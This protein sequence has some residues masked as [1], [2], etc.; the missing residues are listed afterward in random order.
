MLLWLFVRSSRPAAGTDSY[1]DNGTTGELETVKDSGVGAFTATR[2]IEG[3]ITTERYP[4]GLDANYTYNQVGEPTGLEYK[5]VTDCSNSCT[6]YNDTVIPSVHGQWRTQTTS[7]SGGAASTLNYNYDGLGRLTEVQETPAGQGCTTRLYVYDEDGNRTSQT[8]R[9]PGSEGKCATTG[10]T[11]TTHTYDTAD[12]LDETGVSYDPFGNTT[13]LPAADAGGTALTSTYYVNDTLASQEQ[14]GETISYKLDPAGR[15]RETTA[16]GTTI[17]HYSGAGE[18]PAWTINKETEAW[19]RNVAN[20]AGAL[21][22]IQTSS[23][24]NT[25]QLANLHG[26]IIGTASTSESESKLA[27]ANETTEYGV[28]HTT[29][30]SKHSWLGTTGVSTELPTGVID[31]GARTYIPALGRFEQTDPQPGGSTNAYAYTFDDPVNQADPSGEWTYDYEAAQAGEA[32]AGAPGTF[33]EPGAIVPP[34]PDLQAQAEFAAH[35]PWDA[36]RVSR[37]IW[38]NPN[39]HPCSGTSACAAS[40]FGFKVELGKIGEWWA[41]VKGGYEL[42]KRTIEENINPELVKHNSTLC[43]VIGYTTAAGGYYLPA[44]KFAKALGVAV[45]FGVTYAC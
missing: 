37:V 3:N 44:G 20:V 4:N 1:T 9:T 39:F 33:L 45:G 26:D 14:N 27:L 6:W 25:L 24:G 35:P 12:R 42:V 5:K 41:K 34:P 21:A 15:I 22:A 28:P 19:T 11:S 23:E 30:T 7:V 32:S 16:T 18:S 8:T 43:K 29:V 38:E 40:I 2:D 17:S 10:G 36:A 13:E 31:M